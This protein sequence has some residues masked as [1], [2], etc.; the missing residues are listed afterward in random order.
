MFEQPHTPHTSERFLLTPAVPGKAYNCAQ[1]EVWGEPIVVPVGGRNLVR[2]EA[3][4]LVNELLKQPY[5]V[6][7]SLLCERVSL[8][9]IDIESVQYLMHYG[10]KYIP[11]SNHARNRQRYE[12][13]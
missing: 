4:P 2:S 6:A 7:S 11:T 1:T 10:Q 12:Q 5:E 3:N 8:R 13:Y 9:N